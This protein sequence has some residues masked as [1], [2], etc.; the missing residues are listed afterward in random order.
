MKQVHN[1]LTLPANPIPNVVEEMRYK[2]H[3][4]LSPAKVMREGL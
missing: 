4:S 3:S 1:L 2:G